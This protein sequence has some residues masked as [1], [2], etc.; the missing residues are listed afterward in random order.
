MLHPDGKAAAVLEETECQRVTGGMNRREEKADMISTALIAFM[1]QV[2]TRRML[3]CLH[4]AHL[5][6]DRRKT[7]DGHS[8]GTTP[9]TAQPRTSSIAVR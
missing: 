9:V 6:D 8:R 3:I 7:S 2:M 1:I 5:I 4:A